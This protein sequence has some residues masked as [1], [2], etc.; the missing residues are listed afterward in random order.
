LASGLALELA[1][2][3]DQ[4]GC[5]I[6]DRTISTTGQF[7]V[8]VPSTEPGGFCKSIAFLIQPLGFTPSANFEPLP[9]EMIGQIVISP[10]DE[11]HCYKWHDERPE[12]LW[13]TSLT[14]SAKTKPPLTDP[15]RYKFRWYFED[16]GTVVVDGVDEISHTFWELPEQGY[17]KCGY[18]EVG[19]DILDKDLQDSRV[20]GDIIYTYIWPW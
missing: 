3:D 14:F 7:N 20:S 1:W 12:M 10:R 19:L 11:L 4:K 5:L 8:P 6:G 17:P 13:R 18:Y 16:T 15:T 2:F 9:N